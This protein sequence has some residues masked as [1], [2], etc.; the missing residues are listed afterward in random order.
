MKVARVQYDGGG[1]W[2]DVLFDDGRA[3]RVPALNLRML[4]DDA[5]LRNS[6]SDENFLFAIKEGIEERKP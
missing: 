4:V 3:W 6:E 2:L 1:S 5:F